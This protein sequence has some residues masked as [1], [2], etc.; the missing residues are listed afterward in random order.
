MP[1]KMSYR[2]NVK[3]SLQAISSNKLRTFLTALIIAIGIT[4]LV[5]I[6][7]SIDAIRSSLTDSFS[8]MGSNS[9][10]IRNRGL[11]VQI[12]GSGTR[13]KQFP[14][15]NYYQAKAFK[16]GFTYPAVVS[17]STYA[18]FGA[19]ATYKSEQTNP[20]IN[21]LGADE[22]YLETA[23]YKLSI[24]RNFSQREIAYGSGVVI[25]GS[26]IIRRLFKNNE[27]PLN[28]YI[29]IGNARYA[30]IGVLEDKG[31]SAGLGGDKTCIIPLLRARAVMALGQPSYTI[32]VMAANPQQVEMAI[33]EATA[34]FRNVRGLR[35][36]QETNFEITKSDA[37]AQIL[38]E[39]LMY[40]RI[41]AVVIALITLI[42]A[43][44]GLMNIMLVSVTERT[45]EIGIRKAIGA[46][47][48]V[49]RRQF[50]TEAVVICLM[51]GFAGIF[52]GILIGNILAVVM[53]ASFIIPWHWIALGVVVCVGVGM[54]SGYYPASKASRLDPVEALRYE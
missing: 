6:L 23:G 41:G 2:E 53:G 19:T 12:G 38:F 11:N 51:G 20:N 40:V 26:E 49:I 32:T 50:L 35:V 21:V 28:Q 13:P 5:G 47:P 48:R 36:G 15:I 30:I 1:V 3:L 54:L 42:G 44:I 39:S 22:N 14:P 17:I 31:S 52:L 45:R 16:E 29:T 37:V 34:L 27:D 24:G 9:F 43:S 25:V 46:T 18:S 33:G 4:A 7:T 8:A 10:N